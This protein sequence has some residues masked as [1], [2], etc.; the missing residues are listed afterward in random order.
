MHRAEIER[1]LLYLKAERN[2]SPETIRAYRCDMVSFNGFLN[3]KH[4]KLP[5]AQINRLVIR[6]YLAYLAG[7]KRASLAR[8]LASLKSFFVYLLREKKIDKE[9]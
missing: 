9:C 2:F 1:F 7:L 8:H 3:Q 5:L 6:D 4:S